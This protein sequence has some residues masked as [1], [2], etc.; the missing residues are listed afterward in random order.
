[1]ITRSTH[2]VDGLL[3]LRTARAAAA[4]SGAIGREILTLP[5]LASRLVGGFTTP[6][7][8]DVL[9]PA[10]Q[11]ALAAGGFQDLGDIAGLPGMPRAVLQSLDSVWRTDLDLASLAHEAARFHDLALIETRIRE[12]IPATHLLPRDLR[13]AAVRRA[14]RARDLLGP[15]TLAGIVEVDPVW[16]PLLTAIAR[17]TELS[18]DMPGLIEH[19]W[20]E[21]AIR[22]SATPGP[23]FTSAEASADL[24]SEVVEALR[25]ARR[26]L[27][28][29]Q[30]KAQDIAIA[31]TS[32]QEWDDHFLAY[33]KSA[34]LPVH[35][36]HGIPALSTAD[37][38]T[39]AALADIL[40]NGLTQERVWRLIRRLPARPFAISLPDDWFAGIPRGAALRTVDQW[41]EALKAARPQRVAPEVSEQILLPILDLLAR[42][43]DAGREAGTRLLSGASLTMW[44]E[45][46][47]SA[48]PH[49]I[50]LSL[51]SLRVADQRDPANSVVWCP[52]SQLVSC[53]RPF[54]RLLG[55]TSRSW[56]RSDHDDP[57]I[58]H[59]MLERRKLHPLSTAE[60]DRLHFEIIRAQTREQ[61]VLSRAQR[62]ARGGQLSPSALWPGDSVV[63]KRDRVPEHAFSAADRLLA[64]ARD[65]GQLPHVRQAQ[66]CWR[67]W[68][69]RADLTAHDGLSNANHPAIEA[70]LARVQS[71]TSLQRLLRDPLGFVWRYALGWRSPRK[72]SEP[73]QLDPTSFGEL[74]HE[75]I[76]DAI[77]ALE[78]AP[79][80]ARASAEEIEAAIEGA[81]A[82]V[83]TAWP[84]QRSVPP[85]ILWHHTVK[86]AARRTARG[87]AS[88][89]LVRSDTRSWTEVPFGQVDPLAKQA[90]WNA[91]LAIPIEPTGLVFG[92]RIDRLDIRATGDAARI[93]D[94]KSIKPP[95]KTQRITLGQGRELQRV[96]YAIAV[97]ALLPEVRAVVAR[98]IY[99]ADEPTTFEL[100]GD[101]LDDAI[102]HAT[103]Y[104]SAAMVILRSG[105]IA[106]RWEK[107]AFYDDM[108]LALPADRESY[109]RRKASEFR[110]ANQQLNKLWGAST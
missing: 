108:R 106:P 102:T 42:G 45:A 16:R 7:G 58:P 65:A 66:L 94:Y 23:D 8:T 30:V 100:K 5:L 55:F 37:G 49:A 70:A 47:R 73:L 97:R 24:K 57:L 27:S 38:Q 68:Q 17:V 75:L 104:L 25:W 107:D 22:K 34:A 12:S 83:L 90:P 61:L 91:T 15:I 46:L 67:N 87:L 92:G 64:R 79:G 51:Q 21:G 26:L 4:T 78:P 77:A 99:L 110:A 44:E 81:S 82:A 9:Y 39:C 62:N 72:E 2:I 28:T 59:H 69:W 36:S 71:T 76:S 29:G 84:L 35:F 41:R 50:A 85:S 89:D 14:G 31:A 3:A 52:A 95:P 1:M 109:L 56:P 32:T 80:F 18:W 6:A 103:D 98:L 96:L 13:D 40:G 105:R 54:T 63:H 93:T 53:P 10:I 19:S 88:D 48:P 20:F 33:A 11:A 60:R 74:V 101:D 43:P 86:E